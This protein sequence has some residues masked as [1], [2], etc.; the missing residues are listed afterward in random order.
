[1]TG[2]KNILIIG[3]TGSIGSVVLEALE[4]DGS[5]TLTLLQRA[6]SKGTTPAH[7]KTIKIADS[8]PTEELIEAFKGQ[9]VII[10]CMTTQSVAGQF[11]MIDAAIEAGVKRYVPSEYGLNNA[12]TDAQDL[13]SVFGEKGSVQAYLRAKAA[14]EAI[15]WMSVTCGMWLKWSAARDF[16]GM[17][18]SDRRFVFWDDGEGLFSC[19]TE[20]NTAAGLIAALKRP[21]ET[22][23]T[24]IFLSDFAVSQKALLEAIER[25]QGVKYETESI[26]SRALI[27]EKKEALKNGDKFAVFGLIETGFVTG[28]FG[29]HLEKEGE[30]MNEKFG[31]PKKSLDEVV[32]SALE[33]VSA[34]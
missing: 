11:R 29:G 20:E 18:V 5:F 22:R 32:R 21:E 13:S 6:S 12:R 14:D 1:M 7:L 9:D 25:I 10:N 16:L 26:D 19:T 17:H 34:I 28:R 27:K 33:A 24:N 4:K 2:F 8:Y 15:E 31:L 30:I 3:A 23:N